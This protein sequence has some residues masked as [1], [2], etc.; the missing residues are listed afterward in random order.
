MNNSKKGF[1]AGLITGIVTAGVILMAFAG[2]KGI[3]SLYR[4]KTASESV[5]SS[6]ADKKIKFISDT[7]DKY[8]FG[9]IDKD[10]ERE[11]M[12]KG[13]VQSLNDPYS[14]Y[15]TVSELN[16]VIQDDS[17][18]YFGIGCYIQ[19]DKS[20][21]YCCV[22]G[23]MPGSPADKAGIESGD[24]FYKVNGEMAKNK[25]ASDVSQMVRGEK[26]TDVQLVMYRDGQKINFTIT[27][28]EVKVVTVSSNMVDKDSKIGYLRITEFDN[29]TYDQFLNEKK[30]L[31]KQGMKALVLDLRDNPGGNVDTVVDIAGQFLPAG[32]VAYTIDKNNSETDYTS[33]GKN[34]FKLPL[35][36]LCNGNSASA[37][38]ILTGSIKDYKK[39]TI[40]G[41]QT[42]G[43]GIVQQIIPFNDG[44]A[45]KLTIAKYYLPNGECIHGEGI[46]PDVMLDF[47]K[48]AYKKDGTDNQL[49][50]A[51]EILKKEI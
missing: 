35:V 32:K 38:E 47:D 50:K 13:I 31:E 9:N 36:V 30:S 34:E 41:T 45:V 16:L 12:Y 43:K 2:Y 18:K 40:L 44:S 39:G 5:T 23:V 26:G 48:D 7:I 6:E 46:T 4:T 42:Y 29:V 22:A 15:Y 11:G 37:A 27:R 24:L 21:G 10:S 25:T 49:Q 20:T 8:Y 17:G 33:D 14:E 28:D 3:A 1:T 51:I 19:Y